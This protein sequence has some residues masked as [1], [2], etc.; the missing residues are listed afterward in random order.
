ML[1]KIKT[2]QSF[3]ERLLATLFQN[4]SPQELYEACT[5]TISFIVINMWNFGLKEI[6]NG[7]GQLD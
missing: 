4:N 7:Q 6:N 2:G 1:A 3:K 5:Q